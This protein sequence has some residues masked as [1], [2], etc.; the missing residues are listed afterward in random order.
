MSSCSH[1]HPMTRRHLL[2]MLGSGFGLTAFAGL[3]G[4]VQPA[5]A[6]NGPTAV[7][8]ALSRLH[9]APKAKRVIFILMNGGVSH[10]DTF[11]PKP[12]L[13]KYHGQP[14][15]NGFTPYPDGRKPGTLMGSPFTFQEVR[16]VGDGLQQPL[17]DA[18]R[19]RGQHGHDPLDAC[20][21]PE[22]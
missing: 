3:T 13:T 22:P 11:D 19:T 7:A 2:S 10:V 8:G 20:G 17:A 15:P 14:T 21:H 16:P 1:P 18:G 5:F 6:Q 4:T 12:M 9:V